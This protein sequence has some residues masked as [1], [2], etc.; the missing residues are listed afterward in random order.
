MALRS[1]DHETSDTLPLLM[2]VNAGIEETTN[3]NG[4]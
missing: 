4:T 1:A 2:W 3:G